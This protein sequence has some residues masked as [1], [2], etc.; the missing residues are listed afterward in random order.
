MQITSLNIGFAVPTNTFN[1]LHRLK[2]IH[3]GTT[4]QDQ[5]KQYAKQY[6]TT[7]QRDRLN[8][9]QLADLMS[10]RNYKSTAMAK[11]TKVQYEL[12]ET[13]V[14]HGIPARRDG[15]FV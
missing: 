10:W 1:Q 7:T 12:P 13:K 2:T 11:H 6:N 14:R 8:N 5:L 9:L 3:D 4:Y 15:N